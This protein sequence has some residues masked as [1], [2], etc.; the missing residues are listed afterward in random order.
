MPPLAVPRW[1]GRRIPAPRSVERL[2]WRTGRLL[3]DIQVTLR[4]IYARSVVRYVPSYGGF[5][6]GP[7]SLEMM[8]INSLPSTV[9]IDMQSF[10]HVELHSRANFPQLHVTCLLTGCTLP[11][12]RLREIMN[13]GLAN[14]LIRKVR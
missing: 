4:L 14:A 8:E 5:L 3:G 12:V 7:C 6:R 1:R 13:H 2:S 11:A 10:L 9:L